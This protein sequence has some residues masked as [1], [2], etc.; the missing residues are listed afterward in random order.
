MIAHG[1]L[2]P[3]GTRIL[4]SATVEEMQ[5]NQI[6]GARYA[7]AASFRMQEKNPYGLGEWL[8]W[9]APDGASIVVSSDGAFGFRPW[10]DKQNDIVGVYMVD[11]HGG[12]YVDGD[13]RASANDEGKVHTSGNWVYVDVA[14]ALGGSLPKDKTP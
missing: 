9:V 7:K 11:D 2:A 8:D 10:I 12:G 5:T 4:Q 13:P 6:E 3:D 14:E 1:G